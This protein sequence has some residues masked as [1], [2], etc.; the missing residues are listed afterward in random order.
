MGGVPCLDDEDA[1]VERAHGVR[2]DHKHLV[3]ADVGMTRAPHKANAEH[4]RRQR[5]FGPW[6]N[7]EKPAMKPGHAKRR[8]E[9]RRREGQ[10]GRAKR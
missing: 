4:G 6:R 3:A 2:N 1:C 9:R 7:I 10:A 8:R 5:T